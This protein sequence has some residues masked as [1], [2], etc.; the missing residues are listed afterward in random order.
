MTMTLRIL[1]ATAAVLALLTAFSATAATH[2]ILL[3]HGRSDSSNE[4]FGVLS[5]DQHNYWQGK[6]PST[7]DGH[8]YFVQ[9]DADHKYF[10]DAT[11]PGGEAVITQAMNNYCNTSNGQQCWIICHS[12]GCAALEH[13]IATSNYCCNTIYIEHVMAAGSAAG[14]TELASWAWLW[15]P[16]QMTIDSSLQPPYARGAFNHNNMQG[17]VVRGIG[18]THND[19]PDGCKGIWPGQTQV[20]GSQ[21]TV[22]GNSNECTDGVVPLH[23]SCGHN[24]DAS[25]V[26]CNS[27]LAPHNDTGGTYSYHGWWISDTVCNGQT[28]S[29]CSWSGPY[30]S[31]TGWNAGFKTYYTNHGGTALDAI[32][33]YSYAPYSLCP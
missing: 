16:A 30:S 33:E 17:V 15:P 32:A 1:Q 22:C 28:G 27:T 25:F 12:A 7:A 21:C 5:Y 9:W 13:Y 10:D 20:S 29:N 31:G 19:T 24:R 8:V 4:Q 23:S 3:I 11:W 6:T 2:N 14:G 26:D 18:G